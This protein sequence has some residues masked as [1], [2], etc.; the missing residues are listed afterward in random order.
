MT[1]TELFVVRGKRKTQFKL[2][3]PDD[4]PSI[5]LIFETHADEA[6]YMERLLPQQQV[7]FLGFSTKDERRSLY[8]IQGRLVECRC[9]SIE[10]AQ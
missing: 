6:T 5:I 4:E 1:E 10:R 3:H 9:V 7:I 2:T 8:L